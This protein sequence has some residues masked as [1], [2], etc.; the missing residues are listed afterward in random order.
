MRAGER[1]RMR[2]IEEDARRKM[3]SVAP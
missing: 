3:R 1:R 2:N